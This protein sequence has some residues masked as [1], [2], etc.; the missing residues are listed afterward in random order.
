MIYIVAELLADFSLFTAIGYCVACICGFSK[1][2]DDPYRIIKWGAGYIIGA[3][4]TPLFF[5]LLWPQIK[6]GTSKSIFT[7]LIITYALF[8]IWL[9]ARALKNS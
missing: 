8:M 6:E 2:L 3:S 4:V 1:I 5:S 9:R 7:T